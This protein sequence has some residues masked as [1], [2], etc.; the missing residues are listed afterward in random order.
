MP[1]AGEIRSDPISN[2]GAVSTVPAAAAGGEIRSAAS[3]QPGTIP[4]HKQT[5]AH[6]KNI[7]GGIS[8]TVSDPPGTPLNPSTP[9]HSIRGLFHAVLAG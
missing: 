8:F 1:S 5:S 2:D 7:S 3:P 4:T 6:R 9:G